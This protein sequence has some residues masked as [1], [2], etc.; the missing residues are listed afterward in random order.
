[1]KP[2]IVLTHWVHPEIIDL[3]QT[4]AKVVPNDTRATLLRDEII[5]RVRDADA[6]MMF[7]P[8][9]VDAEFLDACPN[10]KIIAAALKGYDNFDVEACTQRGVWFSVA[11]DLLTNPTAEL[12]IA[13]L[14]GL[15][16][17][18]LAGDRHIRSGD[19]QGWR[20]ELYGTGLAGKTLGII[21]MGKVGQAI[22]KRLVSFDV[23]LIYCDDVALSDEKERLWG[24]KRVALD[25]LLQLSDVVLPILPLTEKTFHLMGSSCIAAMKP[26]S[27]LINTGRG[28]VVDEMAVADA[29]RRGHLAG[30]AAD[31]FEMEEWHR[32]DRPTGIPKALLENTAQTLFTPHLGSAIKE[33]RLAIEREAAHDIIRV[34]GGERPFGAINEPK[35][36]AGVA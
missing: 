9:S 17:H 36:F 7:M 23:R 10:L 5:A 35:S 8:D 31:V 19:F 20:P 14:L 22:A 2:K 28:S 13:L 27:Y 6:V 1:M 11:P 15:T 12:T 25:E 29:L 24:A 4:V 33:V 21:G 18:V 32:P 26:G 34:L 3:L 16:R 30:Y